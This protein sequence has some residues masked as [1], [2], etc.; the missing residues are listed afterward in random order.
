MTIREDE[1][2]EL[3]A[4]VAMTSKEHVCRDGP[5]DIVPSMLVQF[6]DGCWY[7]GRPRGPHEGELGQLVGQS[8]V[9]IWLEHR[10]DPLH[11][12]TF[13]MEGHAAFGMRE[14]QLPSYQRGDFARMYSED[15]DSGVTEV[16]I[17]SY[18]EWT[19]KLEVAM[20]IHPYH[21]DD[22]GKL[23]WDEP[24]F[25]E[26]NDNQGYVVDCIRAAWRRTLHE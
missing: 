13:V 1:L 10:R 25:Q 23:V 7:A 2:R 4:S 15:P 3:H 22:G 5:D 14:E 20:I 21:Y 6:K 18:Y 11:S 19:T 17:T 16:I 12:I 8:I 26:G 24:L 9:A